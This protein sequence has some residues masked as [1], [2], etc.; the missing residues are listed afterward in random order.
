MI[1]RLE[2]KSEPFLPL[3]A[4]LLRMLRTLGFLSVFVFLGLGIGILGYHWLQGLG[5]LDSL[6]NASMILTGMGPVDMPKTDAAKWFGSFYAL[7]SGVV[8]L[9]CA[10]IGITPVVHRLLHWFHKETDDPAP[11]KRAA[12]RSAKKRG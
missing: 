11:A 2:R 3:S 4:F 12:P 6:L 8:F 9:T 5:W 1:G 10:G 7:F